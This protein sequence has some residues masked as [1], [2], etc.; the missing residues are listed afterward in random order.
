MNVSKMIR[1]ESTK[2]DKTPLKSPTELHMSKANL[3]AKMSFFLMIENLIGSIDQ[4]IVS[5]INLE[6]DWMAFRMFEHSIETCDIDSIHA[7][8]HRL[9]KIEGWQPHAELFLRLVQKLKIESGKDMSN[10][11][12][13]DGSLSKMTLDHEAI[14]IM[15]DSS[16]S[17]SNQSQFKKQL[18]FEFQNSK[19]SSFSFP[20][21]SLVFALI[22][23]VVIESFVL[24]LLLATTILSPIFFE[25]KDPK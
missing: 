15:P 16:D 13:D 8:C 4:P 10:L 12:D 21:V 17:S 23:V 9:K 6:N 18:Q 7:L 5:Q 19:S 2:D 1:R 22:C 24:S 3:N 20:N 25:T 14:N 11:K